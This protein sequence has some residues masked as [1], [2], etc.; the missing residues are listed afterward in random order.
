MARSTARAAVMQMIYERLGGGEGGEDTLQM[1]YNEFREEQSG[2]NAPAVSDDDPKGSDRDYIDRVL[3]GVLTHLDEL[4]RA[5]E[6]NARDRRVDQM[7]KVDLAILRL[8]AWEI[9]HEDDIP[10]QV[11]INEA[12]ELANR[13]SDP[14]R[15]S[16][17]V[18]GVLG[19]LLRSTEAAR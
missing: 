16:R 19:G 17:F 7:N 15:S 2:E 6:A 4:D 18:N 10:A 5:I 9:L 13:Y 8:A 1:V 14:D 3:N 11:T 12:V